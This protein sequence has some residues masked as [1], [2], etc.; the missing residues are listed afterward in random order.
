MKNL[1][2]F[3]YDQIQASMSSH[4]YFSTCYLKFPANAKDKG[5]GGGEEEKK[6]E[7]KGTQIKKN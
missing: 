3:H 2:L 5:G 1:K 4:H 6:E 7:I